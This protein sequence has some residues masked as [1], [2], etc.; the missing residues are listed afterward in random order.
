[1]AEQYQDDEHWMGQALE[2]AQL[3]ADKGEVPVGALVIH[4]GKVIAKAHNLRELNKDPLAHAELLAIGKA[5]EELGRWR[6]IECTL[7]VTLEPCPM[8]AGAI[9][10]SRLDRIVYGA[11]D[12]RAGACGTIFNIVEDERLNHRPE[13]VRGIL[14]EPCSQ[15]L[16][17]FFKD[18]RAKRKDP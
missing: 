12:P 3:A 8:C 1:M 11:G 14:K 7:Y 17:K 2:E 9:V 6:L 5:A 18:L 4:E 16:S 13:V 10:N 15:I